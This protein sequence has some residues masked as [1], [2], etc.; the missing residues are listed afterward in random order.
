MVELHVR[1]VSAQDLKVVQ[2]FGK[3]DPFCVLSLGCQTFKTRVHDNGRTWTDL[4][5]ISNIT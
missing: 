3:Q 1:A 4:L 5:I 2:T